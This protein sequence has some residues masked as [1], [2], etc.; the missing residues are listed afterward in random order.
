MLKELHWFGPDLDE[1][2]NRDPYYLV[3]FYTTSAWFA[4]SIEG[5]LRRTFPGMWI[6]HTV[7]KSKE[8]L[9]T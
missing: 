2:G 9:K 3:I 4:F 1:A 5:I 6:N 8:S 7:P